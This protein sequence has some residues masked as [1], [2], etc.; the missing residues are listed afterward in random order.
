MQTSDQTQQ[1][2]RPTAQEDGNPESQVDSSPTPNIENGG[3]GNPSSPE[4]VAGLISRMLQAETI[5]DLLET[6]VV[7]L[8]QPL[9]VD[10]VLIYRF[11]AE[12]QGSVLA[13][14]M[15][16]G[17][18]PMLGESL[19]AIAFGSE[20][21]SDYRQ[22]PFVALHNT[23]E[24]SLMPYQ[25]QLLE[26]FQVKTSFSLPIWL[27]GQL[28]G[29]LVVQQCVNPR[30]WKDTE[31][32]LLH[33]IVTELRLRL[34]PLGF[35]SEQRS[36]ARVSDKIRETLDIDAIFQTITRETRKFL[37]VERV[38]VCKFR[39]DYAGDFI[40]ESKVGDWS[41]MVGSTWEDT[42]LREQQGGRFRNHQPFVIDEFANSGLSDCHVDIMESFEI[43]AC[44]I[45]PIFEGE[46]LWGV[47]C[48]Y[49]HSS[50]QR[51]T[52]QQVRFLSQISNQLGIAI[53][54]AELFKEKVNA[55]KYKQE[56]PGIIS[57]MSNASYIQS[58]CETAVQ[59]VCQ[60]LNAERVAIY[61]FRQDYFGDFLYDAE[62]GDIP[63]WLAAPG[64][65]P[66]SRSTRADGSVIANPISLMM[67]T[68]RG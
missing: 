9:Q 62:S 54:R 53:Q 20:K 66:I 15:V 4:W 6:M 55:E 65:I 36:F 34:Q 48:A 1:L 16:E 27:E 38:A 39:P 26:R 35:R 3:G 14:S 60:L 47:L 30:H 64:K 11:Q 33:Q 2:H 18:T 29:L 40:A 21:S 31:I 12:R 10:R 44:A 24:K 23:S 46:N 58:A 63:P 25:S 17:Y 51:W 67:F 61:R 42:Y 22:L 59:E 8:R 41:P 7:G 56:L 5:A 13:E 50:P 57:K 37:G 43:K 52:E 32:A 45:A 19:P 68:R 28:W 49:Q